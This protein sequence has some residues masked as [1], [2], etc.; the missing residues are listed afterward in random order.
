M[1]GALTAAEPTAGQQKLIQNGDL[2]IM[3]E[4]FDSMKPIKVDK[5][6]SVTNKFGTFRLKVSRLEFVSQCI[7]LAVGA[8]LQSFRVIP[9]INY[10]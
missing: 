10:L 6:A 8:W 4:R 3:Y 9:Q 7:P 2:V 5:D 1:S